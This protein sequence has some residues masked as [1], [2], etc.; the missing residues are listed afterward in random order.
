MGTNRS[1][2]VPLLHCRRVSLGA[3]F[4]CP[5][6]QA[7]RHNCVACDIGFFACNFRRLESTKRNLPTLRQ[8]DQSLEFML[9]LYSCLSNQ[10]APLLPESKTSSGRDHRQKF[11]VTKG[12]RGFYRGY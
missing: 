6:R 4:V 12:E 9:L 11:I 3:T 8:A 7:L 2:E 5:A 10:L 1:F